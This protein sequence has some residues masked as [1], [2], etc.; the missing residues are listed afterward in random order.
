MGD[1][2]GLMGPEASSRSLRVWRL[3]AG[4]RAREAREPFWHLLVIGVAPAMQGRGIG[5]ALMQP[6]LAQ[7]DRVRGPCFVETVQ[8]RNQALYERH[9][10]RLVWDHR[11]AESGLRLMSL[12]RLPS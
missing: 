10:F 2:P 3:F 1:L 9:G 7:A 5:S 8:P 4:T 11:D 6:V 12:V